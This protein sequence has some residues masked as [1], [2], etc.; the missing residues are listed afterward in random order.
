VVLQCLLA[1]KN[2]TGD[3]ETLDSLETTELAA[4]AAIYILKLLPHIFKM[5][6]LPS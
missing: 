1:E 2:V 4:V 5:I 3:S 6:Y